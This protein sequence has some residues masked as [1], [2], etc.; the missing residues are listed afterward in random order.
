VASFREL[1]HLSRIMKMILDISMKGQGD[2]TERDREEDIET[3]RKTERQRGR[4]RQRE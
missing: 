1:D 2:C 4:Q 3:E